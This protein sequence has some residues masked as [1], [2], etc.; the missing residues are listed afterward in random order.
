MTTNIDWG[1]KLFGKPKADKAARLRHGV[2]ASASSEGY[3]SVLLD[4]SDEPVT[5][6]CKGDLEAGQSVYVVNDGGVYSI[7]GDGGSS[8]T[9]SVEETDPTVPDWAKQPNKPTYTAAE[10]GAAPASHTHEQYLTEHQPLDGYA[11]EAWV[12]EQGYARQASRNNLIHNGNE[13]TMVPEAYSGQVYFNYGT[14][15]GKQNGNITH[16][17][18]CNGKGGTSGVSIVAANFDGTAARAYR[19]GSGNFIESTYAQ[20]DDLSPVVHS[21]SYKDLTDKPTNVSEFA[22]DAGYLTSLPA[23]T[24]DYAPK[25]IYSTSDLTAGSSSLATGTLYL[26]YE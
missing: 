5:L 15:S 17:L 8:G 9:D 11:T 22:N 18:F 25:H 1:R 4:G 13:I 6:A 7:M 24:H 16:Y 23:H 10:V 3:V 14:E 20:I 26:V 2:T 19:D 21:G 12:G